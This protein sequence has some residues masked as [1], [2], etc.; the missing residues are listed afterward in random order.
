[1]TEF[2]HADTYKH[3]I[4][5]GKDE[6]CLRFHHP[7]NLDY[8]IINSLVIQI[9]LRLIDSHHIII[10]WVHNRTLMA[11]FKDISNTMSFPSNS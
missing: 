7:D 5:V 11:A 8:D 4:V 10:L 6:L 3:G 2:Y 9:V 1:M